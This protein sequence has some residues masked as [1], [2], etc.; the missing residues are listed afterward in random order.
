MTKLLNKKIK[1]NCH[2][3]HH[4]LHFKMKKKDHSIK[5]YGRALFDGKADTNSL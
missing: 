4:V 1:H 5:D 3:I 2:D